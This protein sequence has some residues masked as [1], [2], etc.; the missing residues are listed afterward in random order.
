M[1]PPMTMAPVCLHCCDWF[2]RKLKKEAVLLPNFETMQC[3][4]ANNPNMNLIIVFVSLTPA[5]ISTSSI[6]LLINYLVTPRSADVS[7]SAIL[8]L[9]YQ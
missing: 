9:R 3:H 1:F 8:I 4:I 5:P 6:S 2:T 7:L